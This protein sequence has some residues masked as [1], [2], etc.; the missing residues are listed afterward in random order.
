MINYLMKIL[1]FTNVFGLNFP[2]SHNRISRV[3]PHKFE[4]NGQN[5][6]VWW[7]DIN[8]NWCGVND[9]CPHRQAS[10]SNGVISRD[11]HIKCGY[12]GWEFNDCGNCKLVPQLNS[13]TN[14][15]VNSYNIVDKYGLLWACASNDEPVVDELDDK[16]NVN[17]LWFIPN[18]NLPYELMIENTID[19]S[20]LNHVH[21]G[22]MPLSRYDNNINVW[23]NNIIDLDWFNSTGFKMNFLNVDS[24]LE[25]IG[26]PTSIKLSYKNIDM[27]GYVFKV[28]KDKFTSFNIL[29]SKI[30]EP[31]VKELTQIAVNI[32]SPLFRFYANYI[33]NQDIVQIKAQA[34]NT[35][36]DGKDYKYVC[37]SDKAIFYFNKWINKYGSYGY[38]ENYEMYKYCDS[39]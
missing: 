29:Y 36:V 17:L 7:D 34:E 19:V 35:K 10:L 6:C 32:L 11:G 2:F 39:I 13:A 25:F 37:A 28:S 33:F 15:G 38:C 5:I 3:K 14:I 24:Y 21:H 30:E 12:H 18:V 9:V 23:N 22:S 1:L 27:M 16:K 31:I 26:D 20:H 8:R 4:Y